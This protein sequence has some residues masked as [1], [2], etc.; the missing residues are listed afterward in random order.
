MEKP[1]SPSGRGGR[2]RAD[3]SMLQSG[4]DGESKGSS[5]PNKYM[6]ISP[7]V[8]AAASGRKLPASQDEILLFQP[9]QI[10]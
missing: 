9:Y 1:S 10:F 4:S 5:G 6:D 8:A 2:S 3:A 7:P